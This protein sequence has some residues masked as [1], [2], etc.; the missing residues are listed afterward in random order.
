MSLAAIAA[1]AVMTLATAPGAAAGGAGAVRPPGAGVGVDAVLRAASDLWTD[2]ECI[3]TA[4]CI[5]VAWDGVSLTEDGGVTWEDVFPMGSG[6]RPTDVACTGSL[7]T[8]VGGTGTFGDD[9][10]WY[11]VS[12]D[13]GITWDDLID[14]EGMPAGVSCRGG[15][16]S[17]LTRASGSCPLCSGD[18]AVLH[19]DNGWVTGHRYTFDSI[20][21]SYD[22]EP[23]RIACVSATT[24]VLAGSG[25][26]AFTR[27]VMPAV[28]DATYTEACKLGAD[29]CWAQH[30]RLACSAAGLCVASAWN[31]TSL[32]RGA[33]LA[34]SR[35]GGKTWLRSATLTTTTIDGLAC[36]SSKVC[37]GV[38]LKGAVIRTT[39]AG[40]K[41]K[42]STVAG[43]PDLISISCPTSTVCHALTSSGATWVT[44]NAGGSWSR[45]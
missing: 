45:P 15:A 7:C 1:L 37:I 17:I 19:S 32:P 9:Q 35:N 8:I 16:C 10:G 30:N 31:S 26:K 33:R 44:R 29:K 24:C 12:T 6:V 23:E 43:A 14:A 40:R 38:G 42:T 3:D 20:L 28:G 39:D 2:I 11:S 13:G 22:G 41:W 34:V 5:A 18:A 21:D 27:I 25:F 36:V 4:T